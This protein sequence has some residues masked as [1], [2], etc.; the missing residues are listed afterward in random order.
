[1]AG[2]STFLGIGRRQQLVAI[3][4]VGVVLVAYAGVTALWNV[5]RSNRSG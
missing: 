5:F 3:G 1:M 4:V 2:D